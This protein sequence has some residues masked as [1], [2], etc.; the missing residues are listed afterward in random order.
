MKTLIAFYDLAYGPVSYDFVTWL[1]RAMFMAKEGAF[2]RL[3]VVI[4]PKEDGLG[5]FSRHWGE[6]DAE[7]AYWRLWHIIMASCPLARATVTLA[8]SKRQ[9]QEIAVSSKN[10]STWWPDGKS[11]FMGPLVQA[12]REGRRIPT[13]TAT[14]Q[15]KR[16]VGSLLGQDQKKVVTLTLRDQSTD[17]ARN[18]NKEAW[19][20][21]HDRIESKGF[22]VFRLNDSNQALRSGRG[23]AE[24]DPDIRLALYESAEL[25]LIGNNGPQELLKFSAAPYVIFGLAL[26]DGWKDHFRRYFSMEIGD[27]L[28][29]AGPR[30][31]MVYEPDS[32]E[33][34]VDAVEQ[35]LN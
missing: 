2:A 24:L 32:F 27:Q 12:S 7:A 6:H 9:A 20:R 30:Q 18:S 25:N 11:H 15:A 8:H 1:V 4:V 29:W 22:R 3:H 23:F 19:N 33:V 35:L 26:S 16:Y 5:G 21:L 28:P 10:S 17:P 13:L 31:R 34:M 14:D